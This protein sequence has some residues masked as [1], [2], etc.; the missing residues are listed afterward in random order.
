MRATSAVI[1]V[2]LLGAA[3]ANADELERVPPVTNAAALKECGACHLAYQPQLLP[4]ESWQRLFGQ[5]DDHFGEDAS[6]DD[7]TRQEILDYY[8]VGAGRQAQ[9]ESAPLRITELGWWVRAHRPGEVRE[10]DWA[11]A[12]FKGN[13]TA[14]HR[15][16]DQ[17]VYE[18]G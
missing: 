12:R 14:C 8:L 15:Q 17:G 3:V 5:L 18:E 1:S 7:V 11:K 2:L 16:A 9:P 10:A 13:C 4:A 6:L